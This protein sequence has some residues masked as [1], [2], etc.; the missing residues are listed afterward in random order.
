MVC[1]IIWPTLYY[2]CH[3]KCAQTY[4]HSQTLLT[5]S[6]NLLC[7]SMHYSITRTKTMTYTHAHTHIHRYTHILTHSIYT[8]AH[9]RPLDPLP[10][11]VTAISK[12]WEFHTTC[13][14]HTHLLAR[15][16]PTT[17]YTKTAFFVNQQC[18]TTHFFEHFPSPPR[19]T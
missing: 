16:A 18:R 9:H 12:V 2:R 4:M 5:N 13:A 19:P 11:Q 14:P 3:L 8:L 15:L 17:S 10:K 7:R 6:L 1:K